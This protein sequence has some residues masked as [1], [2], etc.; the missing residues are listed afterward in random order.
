MHID[1]ALLGKLQ[2][3]AMIEIDET[4]KEKVEQNLSEIL[5]FV[6]NLNSV[7]TDSVILQSTQKT[8]LRADEIDSS[9]VA[10]NVAQNIA[11][12]VL[13]NAPSTKDDFFL[14]PKII[15]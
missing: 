13:K 14:V 5:D 9:S 11:K 15:E 12:E 3:L 10:Q 1:D 8:P 7:D 6:E 2:R 4:Q